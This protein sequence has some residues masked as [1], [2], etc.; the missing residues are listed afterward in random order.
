MEEGNENVEVNFREEVVRRQKGGRDDKWRRLR[1]DDTEEDEED[2]E[3]QATIRGR[4]KSR[5]KE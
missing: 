2:E 4:G 3:M 5:M 1:G